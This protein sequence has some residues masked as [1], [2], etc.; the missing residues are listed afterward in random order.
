MNA[1]RVHETDCPYCDSYTLIVYTIDP[2]EA[3][4]TSSP[5][6]PAQPEC[7]NVT[8]AGGCSISHAE[9]EDILRQEV[10]Q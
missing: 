6:V 7:I 3:A 4:S 9:A 1:Q 5:A 8:C 10:G 2:G